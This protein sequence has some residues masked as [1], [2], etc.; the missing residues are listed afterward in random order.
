MNTFVLN[1]D[2]EGAA[3]FTSQSLEYNINQVFI[4]QQRELWGDSGRL[5]AQT[6]DLPAGAETVKSE[7]VSGS[8]QASIISDL[9]TEISSVQVIITE[10][11]R[12]T[13]LLAGALTY[14]I[15]S[16]NQQ[17]LAS[18]NGQRT[19]YHS[20]LEYKAAQAIM[21]TSHK[22]AVFGSPNHSMY[23]LLN[24]PDVPLE[25][26]TFN[27]Y[28]E[29]DP[30]VLTDFFVDKYNTIWSNTFQV[31]KPNILG[32]P[33]KLYTK[34]LGMWFNGVQ[35]NVYMR[36]LDSLRPLGLRAIEPMNELKN[37]ELVKGGISTAKDMGIFYSL[38]QNKRSFFRQ[39]TPTST[40]ND[41]IGLSYRVIL[42][43]RVSDVI[44]N[45]PLSAQYIRFPAG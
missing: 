38:N 5:L 44:N 34:I 35:Q 11:E 12:P 33:N 6:G 25:D 43:K 27:P 18:Q 39:F 42:F 30:Q 13:A 24:N 41:K 22:L 1:F 16:L 2:A 7:L 45:Y 36:I 17:I 32:L 14:S 40:T 9:D 28:T 23:G 21:E 8:G 37:S 3:A 31:E 20:T 29:T 19:N 10:E 4:Q 15:D 26:V